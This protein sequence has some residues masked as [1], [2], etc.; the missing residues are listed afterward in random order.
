MA[1]N[2]PVMEEDLEWGMV[3]DGDTTV[4]GAECTRA[5]IATVAATTEVLCTMGL[6]SGHLDTGASLAKKK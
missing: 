6:T 2:N 3:A 4:T 1:V 5:G